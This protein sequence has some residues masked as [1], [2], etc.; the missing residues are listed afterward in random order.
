VLL[1]RTRL[2]AGANFDFPA[3]AILGLFAHRAS[4]AFSSHA[5][6]RQLRNHSRISSLTDKK[7]NI[8]RGVA[9]L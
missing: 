2:P 5:V 6:P 1:L 4:S 7:L 9:D 3:A 8:F